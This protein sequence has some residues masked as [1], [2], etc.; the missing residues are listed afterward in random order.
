MEKAGNPPLRWTSTVTSGASMPVRARLKTTASDM[1]GAPIR[2]GAILGRRESPGNGDSGRRFSRLWRRRASLP[3]RRP[4]AP[5]SRACRA[6]ARAPPAE[7][8]I[9]RG[10]T[11]SMRSRAVPRTLRRV[12]RTSRSRVPTPSGS[13]S[14]TRRTSSSSRS[15]SKG[16]LI[17]LWRT[18]GS[19]SR[20]YDSFSPRRAQ[21]GRGCG[22]E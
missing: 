21:A 9:P 6:C 15:G 11:R 10:S 5:G 14:T 19:R 8:R 17:V 22:V 13:T 20:H 1:E 18:S 2:N 16:W 4:C 3:A 12:E 7:R